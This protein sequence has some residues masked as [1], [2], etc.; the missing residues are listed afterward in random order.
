MTWGTLFSFFFSF[1]SFSGSTSAQGVRVTGPQP[2]PSRWPHSHR[3]NRKKV[4]LLF[5][6]CKKEFGVENE[7]NP[8]VNVF[9]VFVAMRSRNKKLTSGQPHNS[10]DPRRPAA[11]LLIRFQKRLLLKFRTFYPTFP[12]VYASDA[13]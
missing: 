5:E 9:R 1:F 10:I 2:L 8:V 11:S 3:E 12:N 7:E 6:G 4:T 13:W